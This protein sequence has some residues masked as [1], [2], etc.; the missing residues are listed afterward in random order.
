MTEGGMFLTA[1]NDIY[2]P[3]DEP[4]LPIQ[5]GCGKG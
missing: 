2:W 1:L 4:T 3:L 5:S